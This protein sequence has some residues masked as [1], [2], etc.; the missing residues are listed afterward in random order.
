ML[1]RSLLLFALL[2]LGLALPASAQVPVLELDDD[3]HAIR[4][5]ASLQVLL[6][7]TG[8]LTAP[9]VDQLSAARFRPVDRDAPY[10]LDSGALWLRFDAT[11]TNPSI[12]WHLSIPLPGIDDASLF[13]RD[14]QGRWVT[15][16]AGDTRPISTWPQAARFP[17]FSLSH[18]TGYAVRYYL[19]VQHARVPFS[20]LPQVVSGTRLLT[21]QQNAHILLGIYFGLA[22]LVVALALANALAYR[23]MGF[24]TY[25]LYIGLFAGAQAAFTGVAGLYWWPDM[26]ALNNVSV[27]LLPVSAAAAAMWFVRTVTVPRRFSRALDWLLIGLIGVL[28][29]IGVMD[30]L[31]PTVESF[32]MI[33]TLLC[34]GIAVLLMVIGVSLVEGDHH[35]RWVAMGFLPVLVATLFPVLRN[36]GLIA[37]SF[38]TEYGLMLASAVEAPILFYGL[39]RRVSQRREPRL[40]ATTLRTIDPLTGLYSAPVMVDKLRQALDTAKRY[41]QPFALLLVNLTNLGVLQQHGRETGDRAM[42][43]AAARIRAVAGPG[44]TVA[45]V[46]DSQFALLLEG[47]I[48]ARAANDVATKILASG[49]R[50]SRELP[51]A[52]SL[53]FHIAV[54]HLGDEAGV[55]PGDAAACLA[56]MQQSVKDL[57]DGS[58]KAIR[59]VKL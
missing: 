41:P 17:V 28:P 14:A 39:H 42:V 8:R 20:A 43:M 37:S 51:D 15:Q 10:L 3:R 52:E 6:D 56:R 2:F 1:H 9:E 35:A 53:L 21:E 55:A 50:P 16:E 31:L 11:V 19:R 30:A 23:D 45:R 57:N 29:L 18:E 25:A 44:D 26:P 34:A 49:L 12:D 13:Y 40:R 5:D 54:G 59:L 58:R 32:A 47:P 38:Y 27:F 22:A 33:N 46:G 24:A 48:N 36:F 4:L 7:A